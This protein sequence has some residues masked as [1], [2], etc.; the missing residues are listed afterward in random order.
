VP[1]EVKE[2]VEG[3]VAAVRSALQSGDIAQ[4]KSVTQELTESLQKI[5]SSIYEQPGGTPPE[6]EA[7]TEEGPKDEGTV[8]G[9]FREV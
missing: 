2:E 1:A 6:G 9:E 7:P 8:D 4:I 3:K 5:G